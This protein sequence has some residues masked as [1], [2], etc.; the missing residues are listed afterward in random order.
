M[1][2]TLQ[3]YEIEKNCLFVIVDKLSQSTKDTEVQ[4]YESDILEVLNSNLSVLVNETHILTVLPDL[5]E[6]S[7]VLICNKFKE[8]IKSVFE[9]SH[10]KAENKNNLD[11]TLTKM[12]S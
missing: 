4:S 11:D 2:E 5:S 7:K 9:V 3:E 1:I 10:I 6:D 12:C 8:V